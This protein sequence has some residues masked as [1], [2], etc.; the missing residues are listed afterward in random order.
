M[1]AHPPRGVNLKCYYD[2]QHATHPSIFFHVLEIREMHYIT[3]TIIIKANGT[4]NKFEVW[5]VYATFP[6]LFQSGNFTNNYNLYYFITGHIRS[7]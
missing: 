5:K 7:L 1:V 6:K 4:D 3:A 2:L